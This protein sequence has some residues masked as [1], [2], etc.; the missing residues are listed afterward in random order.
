MPD[1]ISLFTNK[2]FRIYLIIFTSGSVV[3][4][5]LVKQEAQVW[6]LG[7]EDPLEKG[8]ATH[9]SV[10]V[11]RIPWTEEPGKLQ[12][13]WSQRVRHNWS[14]KRTTHSCLLMN[15]IDHYLM[16][17]YTVLGILSVCLQVDS[18]GPLCSVG[19]AK[20]DSCL[21]GALIVVRKTWLNPCRNSMEG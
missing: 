12:S 19:S 15:S 1:I 17:M 21:Q 6:S 4:N 10:L 18:K 9:S 20:E 8:M 14:A 7:W 3:K 2:Y 13:V 11:R 16:S 5:L